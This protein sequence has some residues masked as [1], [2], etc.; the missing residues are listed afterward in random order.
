MQLFVKTLTGRVVT[1]DVEASDTVLA[2]K[3]KISG[4]EGVAVE[5][6]R[7]IAEECQMDDE[8]T[9]ADYNLSSESTIA[10]VVALIGG[11]KKKRKK[12]IYTK[13]KRERHRKKKIKMAVLKYYKVPLTPLSSLVWLS[14]LVILAMSRCVGVLSAG[15]SCGVSE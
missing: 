4:V 8:R 13:P 14:P 10:L 7:L 3:Q 2:I 15:V 11:G 12:K 1:L 9:L 6:Q 5:S